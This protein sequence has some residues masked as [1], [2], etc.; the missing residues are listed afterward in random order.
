MK[1]TK[2]NANGTMPR[3]VSISASYVFGT[4]SEM[5]ISDSANPHITSLNASSRD[6]SCERYRNGILCSMTS[7]VIVLI[8]ARMIV[9]GYEGKQPRFGARIFVAEN[10]AV[11]GDVEL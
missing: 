8:S 2:Q 5:T 3:I 7:I 9:R 1:I 6:T 11:I 10:A 4:S